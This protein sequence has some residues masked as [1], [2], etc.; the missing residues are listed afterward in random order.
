MQE[1]LKE[2]F[3]STKNEMKKHGYTDKSIYSAYSYIWEKYARYFKTSDFITQ[4]SVYEFLSYHF[5]EEIHLKPS[6]TLSVIQKKYIRALD[7]LLKMN[8]DIELPYSKI[9]TISYLM[10]SDLKRVFDSYI[11]KSIDDGN[12][13][14]TIYNKEDR[15]K[16]FIK[17]T[18]FN[19]PSSITLI[20]NLQK[21]MN[22][23]SIGLSVKN[24]LIRKF[25]IYC[26]EEKYITLDILN[27]WPSSFKSGKDKNIPSEYSANEI[28]ILLSTASVFKNEDYH[29]RNFAI[30]SLI[31]FT[32]IRAYDVCELKF[33]NISWEKNEISFIQHKTK[34]H[35]RMPL[36]SQVGNPIVDYL[37]K[38]RIKSGNTHIFIT[39]KDKK[40]KS[41]SITSIINCYFHNSGI[42]IS[43]KHFGAHSLRHSFASN[44]L[45]NGVPIFDVSKSLGHSS[46]ECVHVYAKVN[47]TKLR[48]CVLEELT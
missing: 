45:N 30:L 16:R 26:Y 5:K 10:S 36:V 32:G 31:I 8:D 33:E 29:L 27:T 12:C 7:Y 40:M 6:Y 38:E 21:H 22:E 4:D 23:S 24:N 11:A 14:T 37:T 41:S 9:N 39:E 1:K 34:K 46:I 28:N 3:L 35:L 15:I 48:N 44:L 42:N 18:D 25:L 2:L 19:S 13:Q 47:L 43:K 17:E 20:H